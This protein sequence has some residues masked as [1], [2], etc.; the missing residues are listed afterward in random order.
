MHAVYNLTIRVNNSFGH[1]QNVFRVCPIGLG[2]HTFG[3]LYFNCKENSQTWLLFINIV[4]ICFLFSIRHQ[5]HC[6]D[7]KPLLVSDLVVYRWKHALQFLSCD[8]FITLCFAIGWALLAYIYI[9]PLLDI[10][11]YMQ[12]EWPSNAHAAAECMR[13]V[14]QRGR[15][16]AATHAEGKFKAY[17]QVLHIPMLFSVTNSLVESKIVVTG[18]ILVVMYITLFRDRLGSARLYIYNI[19]VLALKLM[20]LANVH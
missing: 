15:R 13:K 12:H 18:L 2:M 5:T 16:R 14:Y 1:P 11:I 17:R 9:Y 3:L 8:V 4:Y 6:R 19:C 20:K 7:G 10:Y